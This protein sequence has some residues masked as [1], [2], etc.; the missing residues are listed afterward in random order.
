M[1]RKT[2]KPASLA[3]HAGDRKK[4]GEYIPSTTPI[5]ASSSFF[6]E[7]AEDLESVFNQ[8][9][10]G[11]VYSRYGNPTCCALEEQVS[12]LEGADFAV[13]TASGMAAV[14]LGLMA[15]LLDGRK[16]IVA[17]D[18]LYGQTTSM[19]MKVL[20]PLGI[21]TRFADPTDLEKFAAVVEKAQPGCIF[22]ES[23]SN[24]L[25][26]VPEIDKV[27]A[28]A[29]QH[30]A[31]LVVDS[32]FTTPVLLRPLELGADIVVHSAT[33]YLSGHGDVLGGLVLGRDEIKPIVHYL[34]K[35][36]GANMSPFEAYLAQRGVKTLPL[37]MEKQ[38]RN[39]AVVG[40]TLAEREDVERVYYPGNPDHPDYETCRRFFPEGLFGAV[41]SFD[42]AGGR[43]R[44]L[45]FMDALEMTVPATSVGDLHT[46][47]LY[48]P[49]SSHRDL[50]PKHRERLGIG[51]GL[52]RVSVGIEDADDIVAD[53]A[54]AIERTKKLAPTPA[55][56]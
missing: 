55:L 12:A 51:D 23:I 8:E 30:G 56:G 32:T 9:K 17:A 39:A 13:S 28:I 47:V 19:L 45:A 24:P 2:N 52:V 6:Y 54:Q 53:L 50:A 7:K 38:C 29:K 26:R 49:M 14:H 10:T 37:R 33:K 40:R 18:V 16:S 42:L 31:A 21:E 41:V 48:P 44:V 25:L 20:E 15:A 34:Q 22:I 43:E 4:P 1:K 35:T 46:M 36:F 11:Q 5:Y 3:V 27:A